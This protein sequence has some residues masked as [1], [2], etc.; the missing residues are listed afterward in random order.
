MDLIKKLFSAIF[1]S[2]LVS[3]PLVFLEAFAIYTISI[4]YKIPHLNQFEYYQ[5]VGVCFIIMITRNRIKAK[6]E[7][8]EEE[9]FTLDLFNHVIN[10]LFRVV[11][12]WSVA[13]AFHQIFLR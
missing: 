10:R 13:L 9:N 3:M 8:S 6:K 4:L 2:V 7:D 12:V 5:I 1:L 11:F